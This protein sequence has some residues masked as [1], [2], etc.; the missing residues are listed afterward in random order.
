MRDKGI[1]PVG[2]VRRLGAI[3]PITAVGAVEPIRAEKD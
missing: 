2:A 1:K 3:M